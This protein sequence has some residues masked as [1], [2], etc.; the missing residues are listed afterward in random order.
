M[1]AIMG[2]AQA[3]VNALGSVPFPANL[4]VAGFIGG[5]GAAQIATISST[6]L[7]MAEGGLAFGPVNALVGE[8]PGAANDPEVVAPLSKLRSMLSQQ[9]NVSLN[10]AGMVKGTDIYLSNDKNEQQRPRYI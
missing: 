2:T 4:A 5:M 6:P 3:V 1:S 10:V 8:Y 9:M 7:P